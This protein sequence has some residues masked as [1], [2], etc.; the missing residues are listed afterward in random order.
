MENRKEST[1]DAKGK[2]IQKIEEGVEGEE[3]KDNFGRRKSLEM[4]LD[5]KRKNENDYS[6]QNLLENSQNVI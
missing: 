2:E 4:D 1:K 5:E 6:H 3:V